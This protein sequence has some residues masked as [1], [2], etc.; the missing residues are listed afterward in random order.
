M[1][2]PGQRVTW[3]WTPRGGYGYTTPVRA[4]VIRATAKRVRIRVWRI[5][6]GKEV[7]VEKSVDPANL[8][9]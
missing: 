6:N 8:R 3:M 1:F 7:P 4:E 5:V 9:A 2:Q